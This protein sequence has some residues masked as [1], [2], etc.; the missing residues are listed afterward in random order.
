MQLRV[1]RGSLLIAGIG[2]L[3]FGVV[4]TLLEFS[5]SRAAPSVSGVAPDFSPTPAAQLAPDSLAPA[6]QAGHEAIGVP[7]SGSPVEALLR[8]VQVGDRLDV[9]AS[10]AAADAAQPLTAVVVHGA[11][12]LRTATATDPLLLDVTAEDAVV[13]AHLIL[14][15]TH[16]GYVVWPANGV[17]PSLP[18][19]LDE[20]TA[21]AL[22]GL[23]VTPTAQPSAPTPTP[24]GQV[25][26]TLIPGPGSGFLYQTQ[27][28]DTWDSIARIFGIS[29]GQLRQWNE[30]AADADPV[31][32]RLVF[33]PR[34]S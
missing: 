15:G 27:P 22:L 10:F 6:L 7:T 17:P 21:R 9:V 20:K 3:T 1:P 23:A 32:G 4:F 5:P 24:V 8:D 19:A 26:P 12:V 30:A 29:V 13:L 14:G 34:S 2:L 25:L 11:T 28:G 33:I 18:P 31:P 16:L